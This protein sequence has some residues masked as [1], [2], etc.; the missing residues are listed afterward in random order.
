V[1]LI[2]LHSSSTPTSASA[3]GERLRELGYIEGQNLVLDAR[4][5]DNQPN[6][7]PGLAADVIGHKPDVVVTWGAVATIAVQNATNTVPLVAVGDMLGA[8]LVNSLA[9]PG[10]NMTAVSLGLSNI[11]GKW[12]ELL[13]ETVPSLVTVGVITNPENP[14]NRNLIKE[15]Q[16]AGSAR[17]LKLRLYEVRRLQALDG[18]FEQAHRH[19]QAVLIMPDPILYGDQ[20]RLIALAAKYRLPTVYSARLAVDAGGLMAYGPNFALTWRRTADYVDKILKGTKPADLPVEESAR[21]ELV[22]NLKTA[23]ALQLS[24]PESILVRAD[25]IIR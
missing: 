24:I 2:S 15:L 22:V 20:T 10:G 5:A 21:Y 19:A 25:A 9:R 3:F 23:R 8:G 17:H 4:W 6:R 11:A 7:L 12:L 14:L 13:S 1:S 16:A 18:A